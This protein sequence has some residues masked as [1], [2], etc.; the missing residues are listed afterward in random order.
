VSD[1]PGFAPT[2]RK[3]VLPALTEAARDQGL[4]LAVDENLSFSAAYD[5]VHDIAMRRGA[6]FLKTP[7]LNELEDWIGREILFNCTEFESLFK[8]FPSLGLRVA[9]QIEVATHGR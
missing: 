4:R 1:S 7:I 6:G 2:F 3:L 5:A 9:L 8:D